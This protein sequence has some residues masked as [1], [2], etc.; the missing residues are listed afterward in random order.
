MVGAGAVQDGRHVFRCCPGGREDLSVRWIGHGH[1]IQQDPM[2]RCPGRDPGF[3]IRRLADCREAPARIRQRL[4]IWNPVY[5]LLLLFGYERPKQLTPSLGKEI[6]FL[7]HIR[8]CF[9]L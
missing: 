1:R 7:N 4:R 8:R 6:A 9:K 2:R 3:R 5:A